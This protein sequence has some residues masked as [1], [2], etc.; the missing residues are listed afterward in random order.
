MNEDDWIDVQLGAGARVRLRREH[1]DTTIVVWECGGAWCW[2]WSSDD[3]LY[4]HAGRAST[5]QLAEQSAMLS[6][7]SVT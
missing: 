1:D 3:G 4:V 7:S 2:L 5:L 6:V